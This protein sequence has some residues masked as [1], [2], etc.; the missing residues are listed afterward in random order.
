MILQSI[1]A[2]SAGCGS[3]EQRRHMQFEFSCFGG[4]SGD[5]GVRRVQRE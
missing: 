4:V 3:F 5:F 1:D 2:V